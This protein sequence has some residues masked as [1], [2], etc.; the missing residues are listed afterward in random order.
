MLSTTSD[1]TAI[2]DYQS[3]LNMDC[4]DYDF[5]PKVPHIPDHLPIRLQ[6][7]IL[8]KFKKTMAG[9]TYMFPHDPC[10][11]YLGAIDEDGYA[12]IRVPKCATVAKPSEILSRFMYQHLV[13]EI[14]AD[15]EAHHDCGNPGCINIRHLKAISHELNVAIGDPR[16][17]QS[18]FPCQA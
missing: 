13:E 17:S 7:F 5:L 6:S 12:R 14:G 3:F 8:D 11:V 2:E 1:L 15:L 4:F 10:M 18:T 16:Y 9:R